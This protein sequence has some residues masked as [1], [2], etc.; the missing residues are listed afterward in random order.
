MARTCG[1]LEFSSPCLAFGLPCGPSGCHP[2]PKPPRDAWRNHLC[3]REAGR[4]GS[5]AGRLS[6][7]RSPRETPAPHPALHL[8]S[9]KPR[10]D[11]LPCPSRENHWLWACFRGAGRPREGRRC[12]STFTPPFS[13]PLW[14]RSCIDHMYVDKG[15]KARSSSNSLKAP[16]RLRA[17]RGPVPRPSMHWAPSGR[18]VHCCVWDEQT[19][20]GK[21]GGQERL[22]VH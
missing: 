15:T 1:G 13:L 9:P 17:L 6:R 14:A 5:S 20:G 3:S 4:L 11:T 12:S 8:S 19:S 2:Y 16:C 10:A 18:V 21:R 7:T 22:S